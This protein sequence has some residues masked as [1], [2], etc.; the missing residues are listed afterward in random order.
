MGFTFPVDDNRKAGAVKPLGSDG[1]TVPSQPTGYETIESKRQALAANTNTVFTFSALCEEFDIQNHG[2][3]DIYVSIGAA[4]TVNGAS[5]ILVPEGMGYKLKVRATA[6][7]VISA[8]TP[9]VQIV[10]VR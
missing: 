7:N 5:T 9:T 10:G 6:I 1:F 3:G 8:D 4:A 2:D